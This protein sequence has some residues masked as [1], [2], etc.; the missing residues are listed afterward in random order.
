MPRGRGKRDWM[1]VRTR[2]CPC[3]R[4]ISGDQ[5]PEGGGFLRYLA[6][7]FPYTSIRTGFVPTWCRKS[8]AGAI[9]SIERDIVAANTASYDHV[10]HL[11]LPPALIGS[12]C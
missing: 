11:N 12:S 3:P 6:S 1:G 5:T 10:E 2:E 7:S 8:F 9:F 4:F